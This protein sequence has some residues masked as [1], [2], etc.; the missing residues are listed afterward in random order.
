[1]AIYTLT[2]SKKFHF[3]DESYNLPD[4]LIYTVY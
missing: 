3:L 2:G 1:M 4:M